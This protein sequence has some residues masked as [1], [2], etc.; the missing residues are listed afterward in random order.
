M[1]GRG[2]QGLAASIGAGWESWGVWL[3]GWAGWLLLV[4]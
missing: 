4:L 2:G 1:V 3:G